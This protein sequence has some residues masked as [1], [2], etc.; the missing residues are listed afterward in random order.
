MAE[1]VGGSDQTLLLEEEMKS[2]YL[3][4]AMSVI[5][6]RAL[7]DVRDGLKPSQRRVLVAMNDL[8][9]G[10]RSKYKKCAKIAGDTSGNYHPHGEAVVYPTLVRMAQD[11]NMRYPLIQGQG[12]FG[13]IDGDP[14]AAMRYTEARMFG[15]AS[16]MMEDLD[17][18]TVD[19]IPNYDESRTE[20]TVLPSRFPNLLVNGSSG[21]AVG[22]ATSI[23]PHNL[24]EI[25][26]GLIRCIDDPEVTLEEL[27]E[28]VPGPDFPTGGIICGRSAITKAYH[29]GRSILTVR[30][31]VHVET[32][33]KGKMS[34]IITEIPYQVNK[35]ALIERIVDL[36]KT[37]R[38]E[39]I[40]DIN[41][42]SDKDGMRI[43]VELK[44]D[45]DDE[46]ILNQIYKFTPL[47]DSIS[48]INIALVNGQ[49]K[50]LS[51]KQMMDNYIEHR[52]EVIRRRTAF[53]LDKAERRLHIVEG[54][55][56]ALDQIDEVI[57]TIRSSPDVPTAQAQLMDRFGLS[58]MQADAILRMQLQ[59]LTGLEREKLEAE[60][61]SLREEIDYY[62]SLLADVKKIHGLIKEDLERM[63]SQYGNT[64]R[65]EITEAAEEIVIEDLIPDEDM[66]VTISHE[67]F[68]KRL[69]LDTYR[70]QRRGGIG[71]IGADA[72]EGDFIEQIFIGSNHDYLLFFTDRGKLY[73]LKVYSLPQLS[74][75][76][77]GRAIVNLLNLRSNE[78]ITS[79]IPVRDF[80]QGYL[81]M[82]TSQG[83]IK[84]TTL[85][86]FSRPSKAGII[87]L[88]L[89]PDD[90]LVGAN[91]AQEKDDIM[92]GSELG[93]AIRFPGEQV[94]AMGRTATGVRGISL[95]KKDR[96]KDLVIVDEEAT[97]LTV[98]ERGY[99]KRTPFTE[100]RQQSRGGKGTINIRTQGRNGKVVA[101]KAVRDDDDLMLISQ[102]GMMVRTQVKQISIIGRA[103]Q[104]VRVMSLRPDDLV[105]DAAPV[106]RNGN[107]KENDK[108][109][110]EG[111]S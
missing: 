9:L 86:A 48:V 5:I 75:Q 6:S 63:K 98:C 45:A 91:V 10:P 11:F 47:Q 64:R 83:V 62:R 32:S 74:R 56:L 68:I 66:A 38:V 14:P 53:L 100:Y 21:I 72:K 27:M 60:A 3:T 23:P 51:I 99:G 15:T 89:R 37:N 1:E 17:K 46:I 61:K 67:G 34:L 73:W 106:P 28:I 19:F 20:P 105:V 69:N 95:E 29:T 102:S 93:K 36:V 2:S 65:T 76:S 16:E 81:V 40:H 57:E 77:K 13:T 80:S 79:V 18:D 96:V 7:P 43:A 49:P 30:G 54:L 85:S 8:N 101:M 22:M 88:N 33:K 104:G 70:K 94:R 35:T 31:K 78:R 84:K 41:D 103:T 59:R 52:V 12:N 58:E 109:A 97:L 4:Y 55:L 110:G 42:H 71:I 24:N 26:D 108:E 90:T 50:T 111:K 87:A 82:A 25:C 92:L 39:G 44:K 107:G